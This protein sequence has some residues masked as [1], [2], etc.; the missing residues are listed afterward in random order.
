MTVE[1]SESGRS[2]VGFEWLSRAGVDGVPAGDS[3]YSDHLLPDVLD[4]FCSD[5]IN[6]VFYF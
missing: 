5:S 4:L 2:P 1:R 6:P 3:I